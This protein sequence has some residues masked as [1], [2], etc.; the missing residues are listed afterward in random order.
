MAYLID[1]GKGLHN[2]KE[3]GMGLY[4]GVRILRKDGD[5]LAS[6]P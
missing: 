3:R 5:L 1:Y 4:K 6:F 2:I